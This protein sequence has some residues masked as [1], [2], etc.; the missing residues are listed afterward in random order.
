MP[1]DNVTLDKIVN[2]C[3]QEFDKNHDNKLQLSE[4]KPYIEKTFQGIGPAHMNGMIKLLDQN[5]DAE[6]T[7]DE[8][9]AFFI[10]HAI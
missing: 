5:G 4:L 10:K 9:K 8:L 6:M 2:S 1:L 3:F 7:R